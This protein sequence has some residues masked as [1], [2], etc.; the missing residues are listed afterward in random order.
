MK[1]P[2]MIFDTKFSDQPS[3]P[4]LPARGSMTGPLVQPIRPTDRVSFVDTMPGHVAMPGHAALPGH[5]Q[6]PSSAAVANTA[7]LYP[8]MFAPPQFVVDHFTQVCRESSAREK[9]ALHGGPRTYDARDQAQQSKDA[10]HGSPRTYDARDQAQQSPT[11]G[12]CAPTEFDEYAALQS[13]TAMETKIRLLQRLLML[14]EPVATGAMPLTYHHP[15]QPPPR[16]L[17]P[18]EVPPCPA[19]V[20]TSHAEIPGRARNDM[21]PQSLLPAELSLY[22]KLA[23]L[24]ERLD[25]HVHADA[26][27]SDGQLEASRHRERAHTYA[28]EVQPTLLD[29][30]ESSGAPVTALDDEL[31]KSQDTRASTMEAVA[32]LCEV[33]RGIHPTNELNRHSI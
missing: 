23:R 17:L 11:D 19:V 20:D 29:S 1:K 30:L 10:L 14:K 26:L 6:V 5:L 8:V 4:R 18:P 9:D 16:D 28:G 25:K 13:L 32:A 27:R 12:A 22:K 31:S 3:G 2:T 21:A 33:I 15:S 24:I 7:M